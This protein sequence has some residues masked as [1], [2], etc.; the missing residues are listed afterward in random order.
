METFLAFT[1]FGSVIAFYVFFVLFFIVLIASDLNETGMIATIALLTFLGFNYFWGNLPLGEIFTFLNVGIYIVVGFFYALLKTH[2]KGKQLEQEDKV[3]YDLK[4]AVFRWWAFFPISIINWIFG[5]FLMDV[6]DWV[7]SK[8][9]TIFERVFNM[10]T[11]EEKEK[12][13]RARNF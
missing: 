4:S 3:Y 1:L 11:D 13:R 8:C 12:S 2:F 7:Y 6:Y 9:S 10:P 5:S